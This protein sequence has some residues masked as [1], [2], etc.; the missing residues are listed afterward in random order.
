LIFFLALSLSFRL[1]SFELCFL[2]CV[3]AA[4]VVVQAIIMVI[5]STDE[6][7]LQLSK[8]EIHKL[9]AHE[10]G[11]S[12]SF[13]FTFCFC[14]SSCC[15]SLV[16]LFFLSV[17]FAASF[18]AFEKRSTA[19]SGQQTRLETENV[20]CRDRKGSLVGHHQK[21]SLAYSILLSTNRRRTLSGPVFV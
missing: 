12:L 17:Y 4:T 18:I 15:F 13:P 21:P 7:R 14:F 2:F 3:A 16:L 11:L 19:R 20:V 9:L 10:V 6:K 5:D 8:T 1:S